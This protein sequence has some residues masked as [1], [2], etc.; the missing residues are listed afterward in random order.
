MRQCLGG[1][2]IAV[3]CLV[4]SKLSIQCVCFVMSLADVAWAVDQW[5]QPHPGMRLLQRT[6]DTPWV[7]QALEIDLCAEGVSLRVTRPSER[8]QTV[9]AFGLNVGAQA[10]VNGDFFSFV[11]YR[12]SGLAVGDGQRWPD[13]A[14]SAAAAVF[15]FGSERIVYH[16]PELLVEPPA[17][18]MRQVLSG[19]P[20]LVR[21][22]L[23]LAS[24]E[25]KAFSDPS[26]CS[27]RHPRTAMGLSKDRKKLILAVV[28]GR[29]LLSAGMQCTEM[30]QL[31]LSLGAHD[32]ANLDGGG[33]STMWVSGLG[34]VNRPSTAGIERVVGNHLGIYA[35][36]IG[37]PTSC[38][39][40]WEE[41]SVS[42]GAWDTNA[43]T[44]INGDGR[45]DA[46]ARGVS[47][48][49][50]RLALGTRFS[51]PLPGPQL[52]DEAGWADPSN[53][54]TLR[55]G[56]VNGDG[57]A[58]ICARANAGVSCWL[59][60]GTSFPT[61]LPIIPLSDAA[62]WDQ[63]EYYGTLRLADLNGD[64]KSEV[65]ARDSSGLR[66]FVSAG[67]GF[68]G[69]YQLTA[70]SD[71]A[72]FS[73]P[74][75]YG[76]I[77]MGDING[78]GR[79]DVCARLKVGMR[80][81]PFGGSGFGA[82]LVGPAWSDGAGFDDV[83]AWST[84]RLG[85]VNGDGR[86]DLCARTPTGFQCALSNGSGFGAPIYGP[87]WSDDTGWNKHRYYS[88]IRLADLNGD[89]RLDVCARGASGVRCALFQTT[90]FGPTRLGPA[91]SDALGWSDIAQYSTIRFADINGDHREDL[92]I[93]GEAGLQC[94]LATVDG[95]LETSIQGPAWADTVGWHRPQ[96]YNTIRL[97]H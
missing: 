63:P 73:N 29:S 19:R 79:A 28:D 81:W 34:V 10:A 77:R 58:D 31:M 9:S 46:C 49:Q 65:C 6:T 38:V 78:D 32:A 92:C 15:A 33:S 20:Q 51:G 87:F 93:R 41:S 24:N 83:S 86:A 1:V 88:T 62:G 21:H 14:D 82:A 94:W 8:G 91:L 40:D 12:S 66:C 47:G 64:G 23:P 25:V 43:S 7:I 18:W 27:T 54:S 67:I 17:D 37:R 97:A 22:G 13:T 11:D 69:E 84:I 26:F 53:F 48:I 68:V 76:T 90:S 45:A 30:A 96:Y 75:Q 70:L 80:C 5:S 60:A 35:S 39:R 36:G 57:L 72:G 95:S 4:R 16:E 2:P 59:S 52:T 61:R 74:S 42:E 56:D 44:D 89:G 50:C 55:M 3:C 85:D 71:A